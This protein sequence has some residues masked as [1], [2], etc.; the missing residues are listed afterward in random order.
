MR[1]PRAPFQSLLH[2]G[3]SLLATITVSLHPGKATSFNPFFI[4]AS[5]YWQVHAPDVRCIKVRFQSLLHQGISLLEAVPEAIPAMQATPVSIPSSSGHQ[6]TVLAPR[7]TRAE[8]DL[9]SIPSSSGHQFT[10]PLL[11]RAKAAC[12]IGFN[13]FFIRASVYWPKCT[14]GLP[15]PDAT[16]FQSLLHQG[17]SLLDMQPQHSWNDC[18][19]V[20]I[21]SSSGHQFTVRV[22]RGLPAGHGHVSIPSSS[23][24]QFTEAQGGKGQYA[25]LSVSI[26]SSSG[27]QFTVRRRVR[28]C[29][30]AGMFQS[31]LHQGISLLKAFLY[32]CR[33]I[34]GAVSIPSSSGHQFTG[35]QLIHFRRMNFPQGFN[36]FFIRASV[37]W[38]PF[39][40]VD[41]AARV[42]FQS[43][44]HQ[45]ISLLGAT[46][47]TLKKAT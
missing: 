10:V 22:G 45:G 27:H 11:R 5:V 14:T 20:S 28:P 44:L 29:R 33:T 36:P 6:F 41:A 25:G 47:P 19:S 34:G 43:L 4:R 24:H 7:T 21:P 42:V 31:L 17:I 40:R 23:G 32:N 35:F 9:V 38:L 46:T 3:I 12:N 39:A 37:Y 1:C 30:S 26:P 8:T 2:Q 15:R 18:E 13:P 16:W